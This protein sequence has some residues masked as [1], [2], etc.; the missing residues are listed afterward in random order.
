MKFISIVVLSYSLEKSAFYLLPCYHVAS[1]SEMAVNFT[2][3]AAR[4]ASPRERT[5]LLFV[6]TF[7]RQETKRADYLCELLKGK[8]WTA[9]RIKTRRRLA[10][11]VTDLFDNASPRMNRRQDIF[12]VS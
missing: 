11:R 12:L 5:K 4:S 3:N 2:E 1:R 8:I 9:I 7:V 6:L 10:K